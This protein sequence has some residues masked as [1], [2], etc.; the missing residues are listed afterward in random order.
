MHRSKQLFYSIA[1]SARAMSVVG[2]SI[3]GALAGFEVDN[4]LVLGRR[5]YRQVGR[6][7]ALEDTVDVLRRASERVD[8]VRPV[9]DQAT[10]GDETAIP[11]DRM[12]SMP[13]R[14]RATNPAPP[15]A[16][17]ATDPGP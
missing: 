17:S 7:L 6:L 16:F 9:G 12:Q 8:R 3:P 14:Q 1:S 15:P 5:L 13:V 2:M 4:E 11:I 10:A